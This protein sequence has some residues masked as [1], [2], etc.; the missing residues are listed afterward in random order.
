MFRCVFLLFA[1]C[2]RRKKRQKKFVFVKLYRSML[3]NWK[4]RTNKEEL[5]RN[6]AY[7]SSETD[8]NHIPNHYCSLLRMLV[9]FLFYILLFYDRIIHMCVECV[10]DNEPKMFWSCHKFIG[11]FQ[12]LREVAKLNMVSVSL[13]CFFHILWWFLGKFQTCF[14]VFY[15]FFPKIEKMQS[16]HIFQS[17]MVKCMCLSLPLS[18]YIF[19]LQI[20]LLNWNSVNF[21]S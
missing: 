15:F 10:R 6:F 9:P 8:T 16:H 14:L 19:F 18:K 12:H 1:A 4:K 17:Q 13:V 11:R 3:L 7:S 20:R 21:I 5:N 2:M